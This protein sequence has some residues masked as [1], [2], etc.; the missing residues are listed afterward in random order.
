MIPFI[1]ASEGHLFFN[2][3]VSCLCDIFN[4]VCT[5]TEEKV[6]TQE[7]TKKR[8][9]NDGEASEGEYSLTSYC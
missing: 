3:W 8:K 2:L 9:L 4:C 5:D 1:H 6:Q 7:I